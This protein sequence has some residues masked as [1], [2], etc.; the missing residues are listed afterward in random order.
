MQCHQRRRGRWGLW[1]RWSE[2]GCL[3]CLWREID[4]GVE[5]VV[6]PMSGGWTSMT[7][8]SWMSMAAA[9]GAVVAAV[10]AWVAASSCSWRSISIR[11]TDEWLRLAWLR[12]IVRGAWRCSCVFMTHV[13]A[14]CGSSA[15]GSSSLLAR[16]TVGRRLAV[17][18]VARGYLAL[19]SLG[20]C[21]D[22]AAQLD[23]LRG[24]RS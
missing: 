15:S 16:T 1:W 5:V 24:K 21:G 2:R 17:R 4:D 23:L 13:A 8:A 10:V 3:W 7:T 9:N 22:V 11:L 12:L 18:D 6:E 20:R 19:G 14:G